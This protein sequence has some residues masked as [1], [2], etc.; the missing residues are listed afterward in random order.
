V[1]FEHKI[2]AGVDDIKAVTFECGQCKA[3]LT[4]SPDSIQVPH[5]CPRCDAVWV[6]GMPANS[7]SVTSPA[8]NFVHAIG[9]IRKQLQENHAPFK[10]LLEFN[11]REG[12]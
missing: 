10:I 7:Q 1:T 12:K 8:L 3:R 6:L 2:V 4:M 5:H 9:P 11:E